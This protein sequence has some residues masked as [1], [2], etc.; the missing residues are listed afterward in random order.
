MN[1]TKV[2]YVL[3]II[4]IY[5]PMVF[6]G[7]NVFFPKFTGQEAYY[8]GYGPAGDCYAQPCPADQKIT[9]A[10][11]AA[12]QAKIDACTQKQQADQKAFDKEKNAY[13]GD[14]YTFIAIF[15]LAV[16]LIALFWTSL[17]D[18]IMMALF[19]GAVFATFIATIQYFGTNSKV[20]FVVLV[21]TFFAAL[22]FINRKRAMLYDW[23][24]KKRR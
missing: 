20:G 23:A 7:A 8:Q 19:I 16:L 6:L 10:E 21:A 2:L 1:W 11:Q 3:M 18:T 4:L 24:T 17:N 15:N 13:D 14:K 9:D 12:R 5:I 22:F